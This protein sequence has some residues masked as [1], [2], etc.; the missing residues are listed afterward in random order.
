MNPS[1]LD[2]WDTTAPVW[3]PFRAQ[4]EHESHE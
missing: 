1:E 4:A 3:T 2:N